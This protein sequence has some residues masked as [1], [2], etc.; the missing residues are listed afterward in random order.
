MGRGNPQGSGVY[1]AYLAN[2]ETSPTLTLANAGLSDEGALEVAHFLAGSIYLN[3]LDL[4]G[5][6]LSSTGVCHLA[7]ALK[8]NHTLQSLTLKHNRIG[9]SSEVGLATLCSAL[10][11]N[12]TLRHLDLRLGGLQGVTAASVIGEM[13]RSNTHLSHLDLSW[14]H[15]DPPGGQV[16]LENLE[17]NTTLFDCQL[18]G[19]GISDETLFS[20]A[21]VLQRNRK[22]RDANRQVGPYEAC[23]E[24]VETPGAA[25][26][27]IGGALAESQFKASTAGRTDE[28][29]VSIQAR[30]QTQRSNPLVSNENTNELMMRVAK[31][32]T[33]PSTL[34]KDAAL[35]QEMY[36]YLDKA[37][38]QLIQDR[39]VVGGIHRHLTAVAASFRDRELRSRDSICVGQDHFLE[40]KEEI[41]G[42]RGIMERRS[43]DLALIREQNSQMQ[44]DH[45]D[46]EQQATNEEALSRNRLAEI[47]A[48]KREL[49]K[50]LASLV[51]AARKQDADNAEKRSRMTKL[52]QGVTLLQ[53]PGRLAPLK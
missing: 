31:F 14:N 51:E 19:C 29:I 43:E 18:T 7:K 25:A 11:H 38:K 44:R 15:L 21:Q 41:L 12:K 37:Q 13:L 4:T 26:I 39:D 5:N 10:H 34:P 45:R 40:L 46:D 30:D 32:I 33:D 6:N 27:G 20:I 42:I 53:Q 36:E 35:A 3:R 23:G 49:E 24:G 1:G 8:Q 17:V 52:R 28:D 2:Q 48:E 50:R 9:D 47:M 16:L 22:A